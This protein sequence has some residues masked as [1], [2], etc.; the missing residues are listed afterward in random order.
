MLIENQ[1]IEITWNN[2]NKEWYES[3][4]YTGYEWGKKFLVDV[5]ELS[6]GTSVRVD[7][8]CD[9]C[10][11]PYDTEYG[12]Y[13]KAHEKFPKDCC[14]KC[15]G[16]KTSEVTFYKRRDK[17]FV[18]LKDFTDKKGYILITKKE[19]YT[20]V[21]M[22]I[23]YICP[24]HGSK[25]GM[26][27]N[28][29]HGHGCIDCKNEEMVYIMQHNK[30]D[31][32]NFINSF[33]DNKLLNKDDY[34]NMNTHNL[35]IRCKCGNIYITSFH[36]YKNYDVRMCSSCSCKQSKNELYISSILDKYNI[37]YIQEK[38]FTDCR[39]IK[40]L[41]FDFY[42]PKYNLIIEYDGEGHYLETFYS[43]YD[44]PKE[45]LLD[46]QKKDK[47]K[48]AY[49]QK[50]SIHIL[51]IPYWEKDNIENIILE[52]LNSLNILEKVI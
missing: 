31:V 7:V 21:K 17:Y 16:K 20:D 40:P 13:Y 44:N 47:I 2:H 5:S 43:R 23:E 52:E 48:N 34:I 24:K 1:K 4:G 10:G 26:M 49:C 3:L 27:E 39:D 19:E 50:H 51:R 35:K 28:M 18:K 30:D 15:T 6:H 33:N 25:N 11:E 12:V 42:L 8:I 22:N 38:R 36:N 14:S 32:E 45:M 29:I 41:P 46:R 37:E 9:Y